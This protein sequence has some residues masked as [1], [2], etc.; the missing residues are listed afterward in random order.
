M[1]C[2]QTELKLEFLNKLKALLEEYDASISWDC[3]SCSD[4]HAIYDDCITVEMGQVEI[5]RTDAHNKEAVLDA[6]SLA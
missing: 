3:D 2:Q 1:Y 4:T 6:D 5:F